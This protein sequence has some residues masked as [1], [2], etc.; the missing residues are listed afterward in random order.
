M[1]KHFRLHLHFWKVPFAGMTECNS[2]FTIHW[3]PAL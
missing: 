3:I 1:N 2:R